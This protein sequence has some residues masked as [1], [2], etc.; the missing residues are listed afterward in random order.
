MWLPES[1]ASISKGGVWSAT[2]L[3]Y[4]FDQTTSTLNPLDYS[5]SCCA[6]G[7]QPLN[8]VWL[9]AQC[10]LTVYRHHLSDQSNKMVDEGHFI[11]FF[12]YDLSFPDDTVFILELK[13][14]C[15]FKPCHKWLF[16]KTNE[17]I[18]QKKETKTN[19]FLVFS[20][21]FISLLFLCI[22]CAV[23]KTGIYGHICC[24]RITV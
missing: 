13:Q 9:C 20:I 18:Q 10:E 22:A 24:S 21:Y 23:F 8:N 17:A 3:L 1:N 15:C 11:I 14:C 2:G 5:G 16:K 19:F 4:V 12:G 7:Y 6:S